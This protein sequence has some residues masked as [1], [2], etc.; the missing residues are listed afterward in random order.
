MDSQRR[1]TL[2]EMQRKGIDP[3]PYSYSRTHYAS[4]VHEKYPSLEGKH[5]RVAGRIMTKRSFGQLVF[6]TIQDTT[7][8]LQI[9]LRADHVGSGEL[10]QFEKLDL[11]DFLGAEGKVTKTKKG[12]ISV[13]VEKYILLAKSL[14]AL[15]EKFHGLEDTEIRYRKRYLDL[16]ANPQIADIFRKRAKIIHVVRRYLDE[17][18]FLEVETPILQ[19][20]YGGA[21]A[22][23]FITRHNS[24]KADLYLRIADELYLKRL[25]IGGM[26]RVYE[27]GKDFRNEDIDSA[28]NP[29]FTMLEFYEA[30]TDYEGMMKR[31]EDIFSRICISLHGGAS[32]EYKGKPISFETPFA[33]LS[34]TDAI[35]EKTGVDVLAFHTDADAVAA[36]KKLGLK[37]SKPTRAH[38]ID[39]LFDEHVKPSIWNPTFLVDYPEF[40]CPLT[41]KKRG[42]PRLAE[43]FELFVGGEECANAYSELTDPIE[44]RRKFMEQA[45]ERRKGDDEA[46][47]FDEDFVEAMEHGMPPT[48]GIGI[49]IDRIAM[50]F[51]NQESIKEVLLFPSMRP[52]PKD[53]MDDGKLPI[54]GKKDH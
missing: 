52:L 22:K 54:K 40:M 36:A 53:A 5:V 23:P 1:V 26:E 18:G 2:E 48:G 15:P 34:L 13:D 25:I 47:P 44:Q 3:Y 14:R 42:D 43:R 27:I 45:E 7:G 33:R 49:G 28:H 19:S 4:D 46:Q 41:K 39:A 10:A 6:C 29:E 21:A 11:G 17:N 12:E 20:L 30:Y 38:V 31:A 51:T 32:F 24:L 37:F 16:I 35:M 9:F 50:I 8:K